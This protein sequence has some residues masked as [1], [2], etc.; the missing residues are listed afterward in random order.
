M[1]FKLLLNKFMVG[2]TLVSA[3]LYAQNQIVSQFNQ[4]VTEVHQE[5]LFIHTDKPTYLTGEIVWFKAYCVDA[6]LHVPSELSKALYLDILDDKGNPVFQEIVKL[7]KGFGQ[8]QI[9]L[10]NRLPSGIYRIRGYTSWMKNFDQDYFFVKEVTILNFEGSPTVAATA[11]DSP[12]MSFYPEG[13]AM[14]T[15]I[16]SKVA[17]EVQGMKQPEQ[18]VLLLMNEGG[19]VIDT[20]KVTN[21]GI[22]SFTLNPKSG[23][24]Y[25]VKVLDDSL[26]ITFP[27]P[28]IKEN[29]L[30]ININNDPGAGKFLATVRS[31]RM[32]DQQLFVLV[33]S[34]G[35]IS[36]TSTIKLQ[37]LEARFEIPYDR[38]LDGISHITLFNDQFQPVLERLIFNRSDVFEF[39]M[40]LDKTQ[41]S[42]RSVASV[43]LD[44]GSLD[45]EEAEISLSIFASPFQAN[46][47][48]FNIESYLLL[49]GDLA[50]LKDLPNILPD[51]LSGEIDN[52]LM[53]E[54]WERF[55]WEQI[56]SGANPEILY[57]PEVMTPVVQGKVK[58]DTSIS[59]GTTL[60]L[61]FPG[62]GTNMLTSSLDTT[63]TFNFVLPPNRASDDLLFWSPNV[64][65][66]R[67]D[68][69]TPFQD[70]VPSKA[71]SQNLEYLEM[72]KQEL[73]ILDI[74]NQ[75]ASA[76]SDSSNL[77][78]STKLPVS[79][80]HE[81]SFYG[82]PD[83]SYRLDDYTRFPTVQEI[84]VEYAG[85]YVRSQKKDDMT[86]LYVWDQLANNGSIANNIWF[87][88]PALTMID[89]IPV[90][91]TEYIFQFDP[92]LIEKIEIVNH[93]FYLNNHQFSG[94]VNFVTF[95][96]DFG[97]VELPRYIIQ[98]LYHGVQKARKFTA[99]EYHS[100]S[101]ESSRIPD[102]RN[103]LHW[104][105]SVKLTANTAKEVKFYTSD[106]I[107][108][109]TVEVN[110]ITESGRPIY[111][112]LQ[113]EVV[114]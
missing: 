74:N 82:T 6:T 96:G 18:R 84:F 21:N 50:N 24:S 97:G 91:D 100:E 52:L 60:M 59:P 76:Y 32:S 43:T 80:P 31:N 40:T 11:I 109:Y 8:G 28:A 75:I 68:I 45:G 23:T 63:G 55:Q 41:Y 99:P 34:R 10:D 1:S 56:L 20:L 71:T 33:H 81:M 17:F 73:S 5:K 86:Y 4:G 54:H 72:S 15:G 111:D 110:G 85:Q 102:F 104:E 38:L 101:P 64:E 58:A 62:K 12:R 69:N 19:Q 93:K 65:L 30:A 44:L 36:M 98:K 3:Q 108:F 114:P 53:T 88:E 7:E 105:P 67:V 92:Q 26:S 46:D 25:S 87:E 27:L 37:G 107:G 83:L 79:D 47:G 22:G 42:R 48:R 61:T 95:N 49:N 35:R 89:G 112:Q 14:V 29:G 13:G 51:D 57:P 78:G 39:R 106:H 113:F 70:G 94:L 90:F 66:T 9:Y 103:L 2:W 16:R 77:Q